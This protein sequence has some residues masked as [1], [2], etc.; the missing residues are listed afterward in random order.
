M[1][2]C[3][4]HSATTT[5]PIPPWLSWSCTTSLLLLL[6]VC[7]LSVRAEIRFVQSNQRLGDNSQTVKVALADIDHDGD[8]D[9]VVANGRSSNQVWINQGASAGFVEKGQ[10]VEF[11]SSTSVA[12]GDLDGD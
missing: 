4:S 12:L 7:S 8:L 2:P 9:V 3:R 1:R 5:A 6:A 10:P 11:P